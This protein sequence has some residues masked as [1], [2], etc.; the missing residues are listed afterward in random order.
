MTQPNNHE[1]KAR[2]VKAT[3]GKRCNKLIFISSVADPDLPT[4]KL[5]VEEGRNFLWA[6]TKEAFRY[7]YQH[8]M[9]DADWF[10]KAD[11]DT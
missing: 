10:F 6:K 8:H 2:H 11:D 3:W 5:P 1:K 9:D 4:V 7:V